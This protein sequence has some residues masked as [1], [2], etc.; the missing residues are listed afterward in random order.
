MCGCWGETRPPFLQM[1]RILFSWD[2]FSSYFGFVPSQLSESL[3]QASSSME[4]L[5]FLG[6]PQGLTDSNRLV[7]L[8]TTM[9]IVFLETICGLCS[10]GSIIFYLYSIICYASMPHL[11]HETVFYLQVRQH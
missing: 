2:I 3:E 1:P 6:L 8:A 5:V 9:N 7:F 10:K 11:W 4:F